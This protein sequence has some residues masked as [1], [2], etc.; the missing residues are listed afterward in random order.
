MIRLS[1]W[2]G[3]GMGYRQ[4]IDSSFN[5]DTILVSLLT[6]HDS[7]IPLVGIRDGVPPIYRK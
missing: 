4:F 5:F 1:L 6:D 3:L 2:W 7:L